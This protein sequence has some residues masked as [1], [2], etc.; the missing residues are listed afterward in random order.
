MV[1]NTNDENEVWQRKTKH[2]MKVTNFTMVVFVFA[3]Q[4]LT[5]AWP[6]HTVH[7]L[8]LYL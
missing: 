3:Y 8:T 1:S 2:S 6:D 4:D 7:G 5:S